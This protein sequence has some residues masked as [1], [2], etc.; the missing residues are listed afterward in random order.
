[1]EL[2]EIATF[3]MLIGASGDFA[4]F[5]KRGEH[6]GASN[7]YVCSNNVAVVHGVDVDA[8]S[9]VSDGG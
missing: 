9:C 7:E 1:M 4:L 8:F 2:A 3:S 5:S 6:V